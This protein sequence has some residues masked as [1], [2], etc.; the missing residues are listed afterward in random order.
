MGVL[1]GDAASC[2]DWS[3]RPTQPPGADAASI[4]AEI[5]RG[6]DLD[7]LVEAGI[8]VTERIVAR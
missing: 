4:L 5:G 6:D 7:R 1:E 2:D 8:V 3:A